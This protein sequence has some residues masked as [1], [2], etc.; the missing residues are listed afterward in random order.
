M[1]TRTSLRQEVYD[2]LRDRISFG[3]FEPGAPLRHTELAEQ[4]SV[5]PTPIREAL[6]QL[7][8]E[9][10]V[11]AQ[12][13]RGFRVRPFDADEI[14][15]KYPVVWTLE[16]LALRACPP[17]S[18]DKL[19]RL[20]ELNREL[21][22]SEDASRRLLELDTAWHDRLLAD[23][24]NA[25]AVTL[26][27]Q[28][29]SALRR[30]EVAYMRESERVAV[31]TIQHDRIADALEVGDVDAACEWLEEN[32]RHGMEIFLGWITSDARDA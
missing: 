7:S 11:E 23:T 18:R 10:L 2:E 5:S 22:E 24:E 12:S 31:S 1:I 29:K 30:Y 9:G 14:R 16:G 21:K 6:L 3:D 32:W 28:L 8:R 17:A 20:R 19:A 13:G 26:V 15:Q 4:L 25:V 27:G